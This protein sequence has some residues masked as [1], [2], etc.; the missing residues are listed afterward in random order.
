MEK[1]TY[2]LSGRDFEYEIFGIAGE[3]GNKVT[4]PSYLDFT[5]SVQAVAGKGLTRIGSDGQEET[6]N[7]SDPTWG[8]TRLIWKSVRRALPRRV[9]GSVSPP[10]FLYISVGQTSLDFWHGVDAFF[11]WQ[12]VLVSI[13]VSLILQKEIKADLLVTPEDLTPE[14]LSRLGR[15][16][17]ELLKER[18]RVHLRERDSHKKRFPPEH[19]IFQEEE[20][21]KKEKKSSLVIGGD[22]APLDRRSIRHRL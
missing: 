9:Y 17:A 20:N 12:G 6:Y 22:V 2:L 8:K 1:E 11:W 10:P 18:R 4:P 21:G 5:E 15:K 16:I 19:N 7:P 14:G 3:E 13:D